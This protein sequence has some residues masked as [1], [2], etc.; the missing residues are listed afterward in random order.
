MSLANISHRR[1]AQLSFTSPYAHPLLY[2]RVCVCVCRLHCQHTHTHIYYCCVQV[3]KCTIET[4][5]FVLHFVIFYEDLSKQQL[6]V[7]MLK[8]V[9]TFNVRYQNDSKRRRSNWFLC[10]T[11]D[12]PLGHGTS[13]CFNCWIKNCAALNLHS[14]TTFIRRKIFGPGKFVV[15][16]QL[17]VL[18]V[19]NYRYTTWAVDTI[20][21][22]SIE[23]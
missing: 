17:L 20:D 1:R 18:W 19:C 6:Q 7:N 2:P 11:I 14:A 22:Q 3:Y 23:I 21:I 12:F 16:S 15:K 9:C 10:K 8:Y 13:L 5:A 4:R